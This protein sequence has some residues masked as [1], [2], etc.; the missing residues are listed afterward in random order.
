MST[1]HRAWLFDQADAIRRVNVLVLSAPGR[2]PR[3][4]E[5]ADA[6]NQALH[7]AGVAVWPPGDLDGKARAYREIYDWI[8]KYA[9]SVADHF[10]IK[11]YEQEVE[12]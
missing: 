8:A 1:L 11:Q 12:S 5:A 2:D 4:M 10:E 9:P 7:A 3:A 6:I